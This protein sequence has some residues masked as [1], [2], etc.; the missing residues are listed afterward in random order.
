MR[1]TQSH[2]DA[3]TNGKVLGVTTMNTSEK[4]RN[5]DGDYIIAFRNIL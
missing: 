3:L 5:L 2:E 4:M 1:I